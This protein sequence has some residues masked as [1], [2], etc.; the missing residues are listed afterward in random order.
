MNSPLSTRTVRNH[1]TAVAYLEAKRAALL[2]QAEQAA[3]MAEFY[4]AMNEGGD[5]DYM[6]DQY[7]AEGRDCL[8][9]VARI[10]SARKR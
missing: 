5:L 1:A 10:D 7:L 2:V 8:A 6:V 9:Q 4:Q 3:E